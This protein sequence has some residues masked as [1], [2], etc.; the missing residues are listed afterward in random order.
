MRG[1]RRNWIISILVNLFKLLKAI[2]MV[3]KIIFKLILFFIKTKKK[4]KIIFPILFKT[5]KK[6]P[7]IANI[8]YFYSSS[9]YCSFS[10][11][12][13]WSYYLLYSQQS[14]HLYSKT[15]NLEYE[16]GSH[17][18]PSTPIYTKKLYCFHSIFKCVKYGL[19]VILASL[20]SIKY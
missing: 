6:L 14:S 7:N 20:F 8:Q 16:G 1:N 5:N 15:S 4:G 11:Y 2:S 3:S 13:K 9:N 18:R 10:N 17:K 12:P 19:F